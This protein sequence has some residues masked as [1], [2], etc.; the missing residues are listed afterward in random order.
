MF[1]YEVE[2]DHD[3][4]IYVVE[5]N[6]ETEGTYDIFVEGSGREF[7]EILSQPKFGDWVVYRYDDMFEMEKLEAWDVEI[8]KKAEAIM[9]EIYWHTVEP[10]M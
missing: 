10:Y 1:E 9:R 6:L 7:F 5:A 2:F 8:R 4:E 3:G